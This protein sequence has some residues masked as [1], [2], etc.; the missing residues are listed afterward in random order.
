LIGSKS[1]C[2][3]SGRL[4]KKG[5]SIMIDAGSR[6]SWATDGEQGMGT[7]MEIFVGTVTRSMGGVEVT[8][9]GSN[10]NPAYLIAADDGA[11]SLR[12]KS[13]IRP[14]TDSLEVGSD[15]IE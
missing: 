4:R 5:K 7:V 8:C 10:E 9:L 6:V 12:L 1:H 2:P 14:E 13:E 3:L 11:I 15:A